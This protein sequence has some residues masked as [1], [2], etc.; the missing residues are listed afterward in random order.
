LIPWISGILF[1]TDNNIFLLALPALNP[2]Q[3][4][5]KFIPQ[6]HFFLQR[7]LILSA[8]FF[9]NTTAAFAQTKISSVDLKLPLREF[10]AS[11]AIVVKGKKIDGIAESYNGGMKIA[12]VQ[13]DKVRLRLV[14]LMRTQS[15][16]FNN[17]KGITSKVAAVVKESGKEKARFYLNSKEWK[18]Y[19]QKY[20]SNTCEIFKDDT[21]RIL[22]KLCSKAII[23]TKK[24]AAI[25]VYYYPGI[26]NNALTAAEPI[27]SCIPGF[28]MKYIY[29]VGDK[30]IEY[31]ITSVSRK[32]IAASV[33]NI[34]VK[35]YK[36]QKYRP[37]IKNVNVDDLNNEGVDDMTDEEEMEN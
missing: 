10:I 36:L 9:F 29:T 18:I 27:F 11:Y 17:K 31:T 6:K 35:G 7:L 16:F 1:C 4:I 28:V 2:Q 12:F 19:N 25:T 34:P 5:M 24:G 23:T 33:F 26:K 30:S 22:G 15:I 32:P 20:D 8:V 13:N 21:L 14:S 3:T 37:G